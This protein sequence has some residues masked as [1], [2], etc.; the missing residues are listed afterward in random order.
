MIFKTHHTCQTKLKTKNKNE[1]ESA[2]TVSPTKNEKRGE[3]IQMG[4]NS[5]AT[6]EKAQW[7]WKMEKWKAANNGDCVA[8]ES[9]KQWKA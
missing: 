2:P 4:D 3:Q 9:M 1:E 5:K 8:M 7:K 6:I